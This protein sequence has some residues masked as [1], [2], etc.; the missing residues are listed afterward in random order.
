MQWHKILCPVDFSAGSREALAT[1]T[2]LARDSHGQLVLVHVVHGV[3]RSSPEGGV[4]AK[5]ESQFAS[6]AGEE[7]ARC[8]QA[9]EAS[10]VQTTAIQAHGDAWEEIVRVAASQKVD[11]VVMST[12]GITGLAHVLIGSTA[13]RVV[14]HAGCAVLV[15]RSQK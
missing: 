7:L 3:G 4:S 2:E 5:L 15:M 10:G 14:R 12:H 11:L 8:Q 9:A 1:A 6:E 13:E